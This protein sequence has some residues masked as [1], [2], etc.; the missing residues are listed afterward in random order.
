MRA[1]MFTDAGALKSYLSEAHGFPTYL[2]QLLHQGRILD[3]D[4]KLDATADLCLVLRT[5]SSP[6]Q[7]GNWNDPA[8]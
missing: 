6:P 1:E 3:D 2:Q 5:L 4:A 7:R 8:F